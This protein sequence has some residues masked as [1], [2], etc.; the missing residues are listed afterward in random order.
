M[1]DEE[2]KPA[3]GEETTEAAAENDDSDGDDKE[4]GDK[5][6]IVSDA[7]KTPGVLEA[8]QNHLGS[9]VGMSSGYLENLPEP[10]KRRLRALK[11][12]Q[13]DCLKVESRFYAEV[14]ELECKY[15]S[16]YKEHYDK[17]ATIVS[18]S[19][20]PTDEEC[21]W[22]EE[23]DEEEGEDKKEEDTEPKA[24]V[25]P[26]DAKGIPEFWLS[27]MKNIE[28][29]NQ[30]I[31]EYDEPVLQHLT[32]V[33]LEYTQNPTGFVLKF[34]FDPNDYFTDTVLTK[35]YEVKAEV[36]NDNPFAFDG[37]EVT[38]STGCKIN[39]KK[40]KNVTVKMMKKKQKHKGHGQ[41]RVVTKQVKVDSFF[42]FFSPP[43]V[44]EGEEGEPDELE[45]L[46]FD[47]ELGLF[48]RDR[49]IPRAVLYFTGE[50]IDDDDEFD[51]EESG[52]EDE[53]DGEGQDPNYV[54]KTTDGKS[55]F[56]NVDDGKPQECK[57]Q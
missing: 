42:N 37:P 54:P 57:A 12:I 16:L 13:V 32:N 22:V 35:T 48:F 25:V 55:Q 14:H 28:N 43:E 5:S 50:A 36:S 21:E 40:S 17:R 26:E 11:N 49:F 56:R 15:Q 33:E 53:E 23:D 39:W 30:Q 34:H 6:T 2:T 38:K 47:Y 46:T 44:P 52:D 41:S 31:Q 24:S 3:E 7:L 27:A 8:V 20:E 9:L 29:L 4:T 10:V 18:G 1:A 45:K 19:Y 51:E